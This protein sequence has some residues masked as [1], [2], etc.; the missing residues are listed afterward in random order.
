MRR[1]VGKRLR[2][3]A[4]TL[5]ESKRA[6]WLCL[7]LALLAE[8]GWAQCF[9]SQLQSPT[10]T[11]GDSFGQCLASD[12]P[13]LV[14]G[15]RSTVSIYLRDERGTSLDATDDAWLLNAHLKSMDPFAS[16]GF[17]TSVAIKG[18][19]LMVGAPLHPT[20]F[21]GGPGAAYIFRRADGGR[22]GHVDDSWV[23]EEKF[24]G[25]L[26]GLLGENFGATV[27]LQGDRAAVGAP[28][29]Q[30]AGQAAPNGLV[31]VYRRDDNGT[32]AH[33]EDDAWIEEAVLAAQA[34]AAFERFGAGL[35]FDAENLLIGSP[36]GPFSAGSASV[37]HFRLLDAGTP[38]DPSDD[39]WV[40]HAVLTPPPGVDAKLFGDVLDLDGRRALIGADGAALLFELDDAGTPENPDDD[41][42]I[43]AGQLA[44]PG[45]DASD[46]Y[47][48]AVSLAGNR[49]LVGAPRTLT[50]KSQGIAYS[51]G[52]L[53]PFNAPLRAEAEWMQIA[54]INAPSLPAV[55]FA[56]AVL[57][58]DDL[59]VVGERGDFPGLPSNGGSISHGAVS[60]FAAPAPPWT[61][62]DATQGSV[63]GPPCLFG[64]G[65]LTSTAATVVS[66][67]HGAEVASTA[68]LLGFTALKAPFKGGTLFPTPDS[69]HWF[70]TDKAGELVIEAHWPANLPPGVQIFLQAWVADS[71]APGGFAA[72]NAL[73]A[74]VQP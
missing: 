38:K 61:F 10:Q 33:P 53:Q 73:Q 66:L 1:S 15:G 27:A 62:L 60:T 56:W 46:D 34:P 52:K 28:G 21:P 58:D 12:G 24:V 57:L 41:F 74:A 20:A 19:Y 37:H 16:D 13:W 7:A 6:A 49:A 59:A 68:V 8:A 64:A 17:G 44:V 14:V 31:H 50:S 4:R 45:L 70:V 72:T 18:D 65:P 71:A 55:N 54:Q 3:R 42:W 30:L 43:D 11:S 69:V 22:P 26:P 32:P 63:E 47:G 2:V 51:F 35:D 25:T 23:P 36:K 48:M 40:E 29:G 67:V 5:R 39:A 9:V